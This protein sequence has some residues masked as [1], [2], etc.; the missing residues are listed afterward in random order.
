LWRREYVQLFHAEPARHDSTAGLPALPSLLRRLSSGR[1]GA[2]HKL[3]REYKLTKLADQVRVPNSLAAGVMH[4]A[5]RFLLGKTAANPLEA[6][7][8]A[9]LGRT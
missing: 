4:I 5:R 8:F 9:T 2:K 6:A 1:S 7:A 3:S